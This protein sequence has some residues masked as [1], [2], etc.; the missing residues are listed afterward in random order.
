MSITTKSVGK[1]FQS[2]KT[3]NKLAGNLKSVDEYSVD[4]QLDFIFEEFSEGVDGFENKDEIELL[5]SAC[6]LFVTVAGLMQKLEAVGFDIDSALQR[7]NDN[8]LS[9]FPIDEHFPRDPAHM[10]T[11][12]SEFQRWVIKDKNG[13][14]RKPLNFVAV[15]LSDCVPGN[16]FKD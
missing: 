6:D 15:D 9:K 7:V 13:K 14:V 3:F 16:F 10:V 5:D 2:V 12:N 4:N 8:N 1:A 11:Y